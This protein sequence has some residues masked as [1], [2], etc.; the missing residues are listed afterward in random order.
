[1][2]LANIAP[3]L[4]PIDV[5]TRL[6]VPDEDWY[7]EAP[8]TAALKTLVGRQRDVLYVFFQRLHSPAADVREYAASALADI[9]R[10]EPEIL[11]AT[12]IRKERQYLKKLNDKAAA[13]L[14]NDALTHLDGVKEKGAY[15]YGI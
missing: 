9:A 8:A 2:K 11:S 15:K 10:E 12:E 13:S 5:L 1:M 7:V 3:D 4:V 14:L 6:A